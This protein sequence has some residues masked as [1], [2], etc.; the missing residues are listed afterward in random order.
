MIPLSQP[1]DPTEPEVTDKRGLPVTVPV[2]TEMKTYLWLGPRS[3]DREEVKEEH[4]HLQG[5][6]WGQGDGTHTPKGAKWSVILFTEAWTIETVH[7]L[8]IAA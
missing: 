2:P 6:E 3:G 7:S 1:L 8:S 4:S 5:P